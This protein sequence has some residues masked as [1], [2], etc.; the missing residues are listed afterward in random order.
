[1]NP[2]RIKQATRV[3]AAALLAGVA[4]PLY[5][6][7]N[8]ISVDGQA[9]YVH[10][11]N[12]YDRHGIIIQSNDDPLEAMSTRQTCGRCHDYTAISS[13]F[14]FS[15][16]SMEDRRDGRSG[17]P[18]ILSDPATGTQL[19]VSSR[20]WPGV[21]HPDRLGLT[22]WDMLDLFGKYQ[23][24][25][26]YGQPADAS[27]GR[28]AVTGE[29]EIN[30]FFC[31]TVHQKPTDI[32]EWAKQVAN[33]NFAWATSASAGHARVRGDTLDL[34]DDYDP[35]FPP[36]DMDPDAEPPTV[37]YHDHIFDAEHRAFFDLS[38]HAPNDNCMACHSF[39]RAGD[40]VEPKHFWTEDVHLAAGMSCTDCHRNGIDHQIIRGFEGEEELAGLTGAAAFSCVGCHGGVAPPSGHVNE[41]RLG[42]PVPVHAGLPPIHFDVLSC[43]A[44][45]SGP[46]PED[47]ATS[48]QTSFAH[49]LG[50]GSTSRTADD[51]PSIHEPVFIREPATGKIAPHRVMW[52][53]YFAFEDDS[54]DLVPLLPERVRELASGVDIPRV[55][56]KTPMPEDRMAEVLEALSS[57]GSPVY[58]G[59]GHIH[60]LGPGGLES[61]VHEGAVPTAW[62]LAH[63]VRPAAQSLGIRGCADCHSNDAPMNFGIVRAAAPA[64]LSVVA[65]PTMW[66]LRGE[67]EAY[68][69]VWNTAFALRTPFK[70][71]AALSL[72]V[73]GF[74]LLSVGLRGAERCLWR[75]WR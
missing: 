61:S 24:G 40:A 65:A 38:R 35:E 14:H 4:A 75:G 21:F 47:V 72:G 69:A 7:E 19:P 73:V 68:H 60:R 23:P 3:I 28:W 15:A 45:H 53:A 30:C 49:G 52:A 57:E 58:V 13:G 18:W 32:E 1:M 11:I 12:L 29:L 50:T 74:V 62:A 10:H 63:N 59:G 41:G 55:D 66:E 22:G 46:W 44:C 5:A 70:V 48:V 26:S 2:V 37:R 27:K 51:F 8:Q 31:H 64:V 25:G 6:A 9:R 71:F 43:T 67:S 20:D 54:G 42:A 56:S 34:P 39:R 17:Q 36:L 16:G 33:Q